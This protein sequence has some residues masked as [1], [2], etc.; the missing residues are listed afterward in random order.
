MGVVLR[1]AGDVETAGDFGQ[2]ERQQ[3]DDDEGRED[4]R[5]TVAAR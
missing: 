2:R 1:A 5:E 3:A 4:D